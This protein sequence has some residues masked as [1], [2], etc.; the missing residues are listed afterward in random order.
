MQ[1]GPGAGWDG[2]GGCRRG[3][4]SAGDPRSGRGVTGVWWCRLG[5]ERGGTAREAVGVVTSLLETH[6]QGG[7]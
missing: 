3:D 1:T 7:A 4:R 5:L 6:G 2:A